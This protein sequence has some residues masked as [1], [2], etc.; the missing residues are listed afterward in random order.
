MGHLT[1]Q[2]G[3]RPLKLR[4]DEI[5]IKSRLSQPMRWKARQQVGSSCGIL[6]ER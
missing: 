5:V 3:I 1:S 6:D 2:L 4:D